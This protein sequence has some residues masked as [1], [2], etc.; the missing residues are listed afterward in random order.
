MFYCTSCG[1]KRLSMTA[2]VKQDEEGGFEY[3]EVLDRP[4]GSSRCYCLDCGGT[5]AD[6]N[7]NTYLDNAEKAF[8][9]K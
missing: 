2:F 6:R 5:E 3:Q 4:D 7:V 1:S 8:N 9:N